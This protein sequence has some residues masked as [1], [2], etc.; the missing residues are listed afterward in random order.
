MARVTIRNERL[1]VEPQGLHKLWAFTRVLS[2]P[3]AHVR[4]A[5]VDPQMV[6]EPKGL[7]APGL[8]FPGVG[9]IGTFHHDGAKQFWDVGTGGNAVVIE[10]AGAQYSQIVVEVKEPRHTAEIINQAAARAVR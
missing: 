7:R 6:N 10:L 3:L 9:V 1:V 2:V 4:G 5:T 8:N